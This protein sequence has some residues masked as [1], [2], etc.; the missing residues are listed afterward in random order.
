MKKNSIKFY[1]LF[2]LL[3]SVS[4]TQAQHN[5]MQLYQ[6]SESF[7]KKKDIL[8]NGIYLRW[9]VVHPT[10]KY[11]KSEEHVNGERNG[12]IGGNFQFGTQFYIGR[13]IAGRYRM[14][15]DVTWLEASYVK[16]SE[17]YLSEHKSYSDDFGIHGT[18]FGMGPLI[19][20]SARAKT[21]VDAYFKI[22][23][24]MYMNPGDGGVNLHKVFGLSF[25]H[26]VFN[27]GIETYF[28]EIGIWES[29]DDHDA[30][31]LNNTRLYL[32]FR[33]K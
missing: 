19:S 7:D 20:Y 29:V 33:F 6:N 14:G 22:L 18:A 12:V 3:I 25:R 15:L 30:R 21:A 9:G 23:P 10:I 13:R 24:S 2:I 4:I 31:Q 5:P 1:L 16:L 17:D 27:I 11:L 26:S 8:S 28:G 32:G